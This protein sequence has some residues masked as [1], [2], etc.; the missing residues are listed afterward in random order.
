M[1]GARSNGTFLNG[2]RIAG[3][4]VV[5]HRPAPLRVPAAAPHFGEAALPVEPVI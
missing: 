3:R 1:C 4:K 2:T 5:R